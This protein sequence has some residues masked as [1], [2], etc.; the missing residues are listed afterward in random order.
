MLKHLGLNGANVTPE[1]IRCAPC[2]GTNAGGFSPDAGAVVLCQGRFF[3][4]G[5]MEDT[6]MHELVHMYDHT[7]FK[8]DW[9]NLRH[10]ACSEVRVFTGSLHMFTDSRLPDPCEQLGWRLQVHPRA[11]T[12]HLLVLQAA[13]GM[14]VTTATLCLRAHPTTGLRPPPSDPI[15]S[16]E[17]GMP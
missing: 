6:I 7:K 4:R 8:V 14:C 15:R 13:P 10:H 2:G 1:H 17:P 16:C 11:A 12:R 5:H 9:S 3:S